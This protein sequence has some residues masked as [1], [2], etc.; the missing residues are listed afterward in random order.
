[1]PRFHPVSSDPVLKKIVTTQSSEFTP[2]SDDEFPQVSGLLLLTTMRGNHLVA[3]VE[4]VVSEFPA[5]FPGRGFQLQKTNKG[6]DPEAEC[7]AVFISKLDEFGDLCT[8]KGFEN[9]RRCKHRNAIR[10]LVNS[11][12]L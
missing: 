3:G 6:G 12:K 5:D 4:Y 10:E 9:C 7:Y 1:M 8:C 2:I 11:G